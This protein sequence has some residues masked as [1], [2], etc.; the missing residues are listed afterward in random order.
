MA[1]RFVRMEDNN[2]SSSGRE[3]NKVRMLDRDVPVIRQM[4]IKRLKRLGMTQLANLLN[5]HSGKV[6]FPQSKGKRI[7]PD[8]WKDHAG[9]NARA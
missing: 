1:L 9:A 5:R 4:K 8:V 2:S 7:S 6:F 3:R